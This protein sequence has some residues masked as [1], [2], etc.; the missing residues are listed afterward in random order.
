MN[1]QIQELR[2]TTINTDSR[3]GFGILVPNASYISD[4]LYDFGWSEKDDVCETLTKTTLLEVSKCIEICI[5]HMMNG[6]YGLPNGE[7]N[8]WNYVQEYIE[9][10]QDTLYALEESHTK[11]A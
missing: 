9:N 2:N 1:S 7:L 6:Q 3:F 4:I 8:F 10:D 11:S 5:Q